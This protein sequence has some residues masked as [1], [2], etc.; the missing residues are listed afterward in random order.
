MDFFLNTGIGYPEKSI[1]AGT[2]YPSTIARGTS[3]H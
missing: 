3:P 2:G 1:P